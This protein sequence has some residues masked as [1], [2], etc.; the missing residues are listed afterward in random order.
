MRGGRNSVFSGLVNKEE[1]LLSSGMR[2]GRK[3]LVIWES[4]PDSS[5]MIVLS[6]SDELKEVERS[7][8][9]DPSDELPPKPKED[10]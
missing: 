5:G 8:A 1:L 2:G 10:G 4:H 3:S 7:E 9:G 6:K